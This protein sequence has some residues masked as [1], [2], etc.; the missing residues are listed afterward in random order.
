MKRILLVLKVALITAAMMVATVTPAL[1]KEKIDYYQCT[2]SGPGETETAVS[3]KEA[4][5]YERAGYTCV[6]LF[7]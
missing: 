3:K 6:K 5:Q 7:G 4:K 1:A 2:P